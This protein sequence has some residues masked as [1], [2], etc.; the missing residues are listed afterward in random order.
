[1]SAASRTFWDWVLNWM[2]WHMAD[3]SCVTFWRISSS[4]RYICYDTGNSDHP[5]HVFFIAV[6]AV[7]KYK[8]FV[9]FP[10]FFV[11]IINT[12]VAYWIYRKYLSLSDM[13]S[14]S[15]ARWY[16]PNMNTI[17]GA[18]QLTHWGRDKRATIDTFNRI[19]VN[20]MLEFRLT[21]HWILFLRVQLT[22]FQHWFR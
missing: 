20:E 8:F 22:I 18:W 9:M 19:F 11:R 7:T 16:Q 6:L 14:H 1:M 4:Y 15:Y 10:V 3:P 5:F 21:F 2:G 13:S 12:S 17:C